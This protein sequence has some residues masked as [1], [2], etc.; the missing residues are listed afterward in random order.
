MESFSLAQAGT[1]LAK[2]QLSRLVFGISPEEASFARR[3]F[4]GGDVRQ[5]ERL[6]HIGRVFLHGYHSALEAREPEAL[7][8]RLNTVEAVPWAGGIPANPRVEL[9]DRGFAF[10]G[11]AM[12]LTLLDQLT[13]WKRGRLQAFLDG[14]GRAHVYM[15]H[16]GSGWALARLH[17]P[18]GPA[19]RRLDPLLGW[20]AVDG[21]G[22]H[23]GYFHWPRYTMGQ[24]NVPRHLS[25]YAARIFD[26]GLGRSLWFVNGAEI[27]RIERT[28]VHFPPSRHGDLWSGVGLACA[29]AGG[30]D[31]EAIESLRRTAGPHGAQ[32][33]QGAAF[34]AKA[35][36]RAGNP[37]PHT[38]LACQVLCGLS[39]HAAAGVTDAALD[40]L[41]DGLT[42]KG[43]DP[44]YEVWRK[45]IRTHLAAEVS[46]P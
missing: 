10:E 5:R 11:A 38:E 46:L 4:Q 36:Q 2:G 33:A 12:G 31:R 7:A 42:T 17:R 13:P 3:G 34:A 22:F 29:Y 8:R 23:E 1:R 32:L 35:R 6:E 45:R 26:Q 39:A 30:A 16:V 24:R 20:L 14:P 27:Q 28:V 25:G 44:A 40:G 18:V 19:L 37:A 15:V 9:E 43:P 41:T 21:Y